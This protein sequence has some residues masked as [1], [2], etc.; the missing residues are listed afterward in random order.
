MQ[1]A[2]GIM[3]IEFDIAYFL[4]SIGCEIKFTGDVIQ[5]KQELFDIKR[6]VHVFLH[7]LRSVLKMKGFIECFSAQVEQDVYICR[8]GEYDVD[9]CEE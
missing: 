5:L 8:C 9:G 7:I 4:S 3:L 6:S 2:L 1:I